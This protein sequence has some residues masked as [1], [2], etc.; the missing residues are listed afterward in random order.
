MAHPGS[1]AAE[2]PICGNCK[3]FE[4]EA[5]NGFR[6]KCRRYPPVIVTGGRSQMDPNPGRTYMVRIKSDFPETFAND[7]CGE[8]AKH[9]TAGA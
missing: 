1:P 4:R 3:H 8:F 5:P 6:G 7:F 9:A 2:A